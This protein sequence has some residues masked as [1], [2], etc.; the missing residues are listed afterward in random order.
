LLNAEFEKH[1]ASEC[2]AL[3][4]PKV[5]LDFSGKKG[6][7]E[8]RK[9][10]ASNSRLSSV[11][12]EGEQKV[13]AL[14]DFLA[15]MS[16]GEETSPI[17]FDDPVNSLDYRRMEYVVDRL[18]DLA[19]ARQVVIFSHNIYFAISLLNAARERKLGSFFY[20]ISRDDGRIGL[21]SLSG[22]PRTDSIS[23][24]SGKINKLIEAAGGTDGDVRAALIEQ[25]YAFI[26]S[27]CE[28]VVELE[29]L[30]GVTRRYQAQVSI[31]QLDKIDVEKFAALRPTI[32]TL[33][34]KACRAITAHSQPIETL[35]VRATLDELRSDWK[36][37]LDAR[38]VFKSAR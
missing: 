22:G 8:R 26:R 10:I 7:A 31:T 20:Q 4:A 34:K 32:M 12:S 29:M 30:S 21:V 11:L 33:Y 14:A 28:V 18:L 23:E 1:F 35:G 15:E 2:E 37:G 6:K 16:T 3:R 5:T 9:T 24:L 25:A 19:G 38:T 36:S 27:W 13:I 17:I